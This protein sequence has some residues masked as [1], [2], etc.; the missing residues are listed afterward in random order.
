MSRNIA[1][2]WYGTKAQGFAS[3]SLDVQIDC[4]AICS[5]A[6]AVFFKNNLVDKMHTRYFSEKFLLTEVSAVKKEFEKFYF[7]KLPSSITLIS[8]ACLTQNFNLKVVLGFHDS[9]SYFEIESLEM[10]KGSLK[11]VLRGDL[12]F[13]DNEALS[14]HDLYA[15]VSDAVEKASQFSMTIDRMSERVSEE[16]FTS[17]GHIP[18]LYLKLMGHFKELE[19]HDVSIVCFQYFNKSKEISQST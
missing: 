3:N 14:T 6:D 18:G 2:D 12:D 1:I 15:V 11:F 16:V 10:G 9:P 17:L 4:S 5:P 7:D 13:R 8:K 19:D